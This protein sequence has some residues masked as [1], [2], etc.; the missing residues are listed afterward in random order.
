MRV[1]F[2]GTGIMGGRMAANL[3]RYG[4]VLH[5]HN[6]TRHRTTALVEA[7]ASWA[8]TAGEAAERAEVLFTMLAHPESVETMALGGGGFLERMRPGTIWIDCSTVKPSFSR[9]MAGEAARREVRFLDA[10]VSGSKAQAENADLTFF[11]GGE[12][13]DLDACRAL[14]EVLGR[15][16]VHVGGH[17]MGAAMKI[18]INNLLGTAMG[19][20]S[21]S[22]VLGEA[23]GISQE[24]LFEII[25]GSIVAPKVIALKREKII[26]ED[27]EP[28]FPLRWIQ[29]DL[30]MVTETAFELGVSMPLGNASKEIYQLAVRRGLGDL[31]FSAI[32][33]FL[34]ERSL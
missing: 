8:E 21:E 1:G 30:E 22:M 3:L 14:L 9:R 31:D 6:R 13:A 4:Y 27:Y 23:L 10:P 2:V 20:F 28:E 11:V 7:G 16:V 17:G 29:K 32:Y 5:V 18:V 33:A 24:K 26:L 19:A 15:A 25:L 34:K 12:P